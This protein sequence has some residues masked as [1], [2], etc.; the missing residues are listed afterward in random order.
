MTASGKPGEGEPIPEALI[1]LLLTS[2]L[3]TAAQTRSITEE[4][5][6]RSSIP[7]A[8]ETMIRNFPKN[9]HPMTQ[10]KMAL[11]ACQPNSKFAEAYHNGVPKTK[12]Q[13]NSYHSCAFSYSCPYYS[14]LR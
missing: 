14:T 10:L 3:P 11:L 7:A 9:M 1:W 5:N 8:V 6:D 12:V 4:L 2:E 13:S